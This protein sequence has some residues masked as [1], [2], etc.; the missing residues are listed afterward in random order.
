MHLT[1]KGGMIS[2]TVKEGARMCNERFL[3]RN[4]SLCRRSG[5]ARPKLKHRGG[6]AAVEYMIMAGMLVLAAT[7][8]AVFLYTFKEHGGRVLD[9]VASEYP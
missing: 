4:A 3:E 1:V 8:F 5:Q 2:S 7:I 9:L 6:Q